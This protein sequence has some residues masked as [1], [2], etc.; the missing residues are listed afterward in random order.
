M[1]NLGPEALSCS[2]FYSALK[3][4]YR[5]YL[6]EAYANHWTVCVPQ[7]CSLRGPL[8]PFIVRRRGAAAT[9]DAT[10]RTGYTNSS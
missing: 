2:V 10:V 7:N 6:E 8:L 9:H 5:R 1:Q 3:T 4:V